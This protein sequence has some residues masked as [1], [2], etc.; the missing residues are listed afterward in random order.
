MKKKLTIVLLITG[1]ANLTGMIM[2]GCEDKTHP[3]EGPDESYG[4]L[5]LVRGNYWKYVMNV[6]ELRCGD[7]PECL[8]VKKECK[9]RCDWE[10]G[11]DLND[12]NMTLQ[13]C[14]RSAMGD[15]VRNNI[16]YQQYYSCANHARTHARECK[17]DC[18][19]KECMNILC[20]LGVTVK[21][22]FVHECDQSV[23]YYQVYSDTV[24]S[25]VDVN[26]ETVYVMGSRSRLRLNREGGVY[27]YGIGDIVYSTPTLEFMYPAH[28]GDTYVVNYEEK[29]SYDAIVESVNE[30]VSVTG[31]TFTCY[32][33]RFVRIDLNECG[34]HEEW[35]YY[36]AP[37]IGII[38]V[39]AQ[40]YRFYDERDR[41]YKF[42]KSIKSELQNYNVAYHN[43]E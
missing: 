2:I 36:I 41:R 35:V 22:C 37:G 20:S 10:L 9:D 39:Q 32:K 12:C 8:R 31:G 6:V 34:C 4:M 16:C 18:D 1:L 7:H 21:K 38:K 43:P 23:P 40:N 11:R 3:L 30:K 14:K 13:A 33:Y 42:R 26:G 29:G 27:C 17:E 15:P 19:R 25:A 28:V 5:P 24:S